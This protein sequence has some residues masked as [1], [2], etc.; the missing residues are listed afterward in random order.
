MEPIVATGILDDVTSLIT[1]AITWMGQFLSEI[2][3][4]SS[5]I[6][7]TF[8]VALPLVGLGVSLLQRLLSTRA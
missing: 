2:T 8:V 1:A 4:D 7:V 6:L 3:S 5:K